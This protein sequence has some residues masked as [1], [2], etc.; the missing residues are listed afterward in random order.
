MAAHGDLPGGVGLRDRGPAP[1]FDAHGPGP[2]GG[3]RYVRPLLLVGAHGGAGVSTLAAL[4][5]PAFDV[6]VVRDWSAF[7]NPQRHPLAV[8]TGWTV[9]AAGQAVAQVAGAVRAGMPPRVLIVV[10]DGWPEPKAARVRFRLLETQVGQ[11]VRVPFVRGWRYADRPDP[12]TVPRPV[13][14]ALEEVR[15]AVYGPVRR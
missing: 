15:A 5:Q 9:S 1:V 6:G 11:V 10:A 14:R 3:G 13:L 8:V 12:A 7:A 4:L 2:G